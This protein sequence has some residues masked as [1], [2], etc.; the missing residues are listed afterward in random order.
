MLSTSYR[1]KNFAHV[2]DKFLALGLRL[3]D[4]MIKASVI[5]GGLVGLERGLAPG[6]P[7]SITLFKLIDGEFRLEDCWNHYRRA[8]RRIQPVAVVHA[9]R[10]LHCS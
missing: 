5:P 9:G 2:L 7:A 10:Y 4:I 1:A 6:Q 8:T 3:E